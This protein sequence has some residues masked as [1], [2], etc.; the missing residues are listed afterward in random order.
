MKRK[1]NFKR[2]MTSLSIL[3]FCGILFAK[4]S[5]TPEKNPATSSKP[6][7]QGCCRIKMAGGGYDYFVSTEEDCVSHKQFHSFLK[8]RTLCFESFP[9]QF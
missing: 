5:E 2:W 7:A 9:E 6:T 1:S 8:E 3:I 4:E